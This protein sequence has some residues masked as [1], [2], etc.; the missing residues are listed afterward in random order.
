MAASALGMN[1]LKAVWNIILPQAL[2]LSIPGWSNEYP[3]MLTES[4]ITY[5]IGVTEVLTRVAS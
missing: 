4:S 5:A 1:K 3:A 2:R